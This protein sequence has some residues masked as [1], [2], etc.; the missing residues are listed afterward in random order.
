MTGVER[1]KIKQFNSRGS[2]QRCSPVYRS[3]E[4]AC[5]IVMALRSKLTVWEEDQFTVLSGQGIK[6]R[7]A[8]VAEWVAKALPLV[9]RG[10]W[11]CV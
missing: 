7:E 6:K 9:K 3:C 4:N 10:V 2:A 1:G 8:R 11:G 5:R